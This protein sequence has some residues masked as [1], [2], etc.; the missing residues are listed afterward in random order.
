MVDSELQLE[1]VGRRAGRGEHHARIVDQQVHRGELRGDRLACGAYLT[2]RAKFSAT[3]AIRVVSSPRSAQPGE[4]RKLS[5]S[6]TAA[7][8]SAPAEASVAAPRR[9]WW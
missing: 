9:R 2:R 1:T 4:A 7:M 3:A 6:R 8:T 5:G